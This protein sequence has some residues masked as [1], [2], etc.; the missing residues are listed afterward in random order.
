M[1]DYSVLF[2]AD[3]SLNY[4]FGHLSRCLQIAEGLEEDGLSCGFICGE[5]DVETL[6]RIQGAGHAVY[7]IPAGLVY[8]EEVDFYPPRL[9]ALILDLGHRDNIQSP[10]R[11]VPYLERLAEAG[12]PLAF[13]D[14][15]FEDTFRPP[16]PVPEF[17]AYIQPYLGAAGDVKPNAEHWVCGSQYAIMAS[18]YANAREKEVK[19]VAENILITFGGSDPQGLTAQLMEGLG[20]KVDGFNVRVIIG[21]Y[22]SEGHKERIHALSGGFEIL[23]PQDGMLPHYEW[24]DMAISTSGLSRYEFAAMGL[25]AVFASLYPAHIRSS[26]IFDECGIARHLGLASDLSSEDW[27]TAVMGLAGDKNVRTEM[28]QAGQKHIDGCGLKRL[29]K[30]LIEIFDLG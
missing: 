27:G 28:S 10:E 1:A 3:A 2:R 30:S 22:F 21:P 11:L 14:G 5:G 26:E 12:I 29:C 19:D 15:L 17:K 25:P 24:A 20:G 13:I 6:E 18:E 23:G 7:K 8:H 4:G 9:K 16:C